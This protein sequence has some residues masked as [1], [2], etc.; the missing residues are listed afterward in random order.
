MLFDIDNLQ[1]TAR[2]EKNNNCYIEIALKQAIEPV[3]FDHLI[4]RLLVR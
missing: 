1:R 4:Y 3:V 2:T